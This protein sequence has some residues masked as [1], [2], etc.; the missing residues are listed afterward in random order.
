MADITSHIC[1]VAENDVSLVFTTA[2]MKV[3][4]RGELHLGILFENMRRLGF[5]FEL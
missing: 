5:E 2:D 3:Q 4:G 1:K